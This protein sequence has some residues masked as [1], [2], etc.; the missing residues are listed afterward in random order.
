M[1]EDIFLHSK[2]VNYFLP[3]LTGSCFDI[4]R[5]NSITP[6]AKTVLEHRL[7]RFMAKH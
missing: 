7:T 4:I 5:A 6:E 3:R 2:A 1:E